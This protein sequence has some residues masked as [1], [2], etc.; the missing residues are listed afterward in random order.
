MT[1][2]T[3]KSMDCEGNEMTVK[4]LLEYVREIVTDYAVKQILHNG[5]AEKFSP[6][7]KFYPLHIVKTLNTFAS[8]IL[9]FAISHI[10]FK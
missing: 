1:P 7:T 2:L 6:L 5:I 9:A 8:Q 10:A 4:E 3:P